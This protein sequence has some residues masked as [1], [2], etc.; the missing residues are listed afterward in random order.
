MALTRDELAARV[1]L[2][3]RDGEYVNLGIGLPTLVPNYLP[4]DVTVVLQSENGILGTGPYPTETAVD[5]DLINAGKET[6]TV[7]PGASFFDSATSF[8]M[9][10]GGHIDA[11]ILGAMQVSASGDI[12]NWMIPG[13][14]VKGMG[15]AMDLVHG[16]KRV[17]VMMEHVAK[18]GSHKI[19]EDCTLP[20]TGKGVVDRIIT[21]LAV[22]D[23]RPEGLV[24]V[25]TAPGVSQDDVFAATGAPLQLGVLDVV[26][27]EHRG[28]GGLAEVV[29]R[30]AVARELV[31]GVHRVVD[32]HPRPARL[33][34][35]DGREDA[36]ER[37]LLHPAAVGRTE[38]HDGR[39]GEVAVGALEDG[40]GVLG[41]RG[42]R[43]AR[44]AHDGGLRVVPEVHPRVDR[45]AVPADGDAGTVDVAEGLAVGRLDDLEDVDAVLLREA[46][47]LVGQPDVHVAVGRLGELGHLRGLAAAEVPDAVAA[48]QVGAVVE[49][50][51]GLVE[52]DPALAALGVDAADELGVA[53]QVGEDPAGV[54]ALGAEDQREV[55]AGAQARDLLDHRREAGARGAD[56]QRGL[57]GDEG[58]G[59]EAAGDLAGGGVHPAEVR[60][61]LDVDEERH[62]DDDG[63]ALGDGRGGVGGGPQ[64]ARRRDVG[65]QLGELRLARER[66]LAGVDEVDG[67]RVHVGA[68]DLVALG[69]E[70]HGQRE[71]D[72][73]Q[74]DDGDLHGD[75]PR[76]SETAEIPGYRAAAPLPD[77]RARLRGVRSGPPGPVPAVRGGRLHRA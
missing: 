13:K 2:E 12:A 27:L 21:D 48:R 62:D 25:E 28:V 77:H 8:G 54:D 72:L 30:E 46:G 26:G 47:E 32:Q 15:G 4:A 41:H 7:L 36:G 61:A 43:L 55:D 34:R 69:G 10:R 42:V 22:I 75:G 1:A 70:L 6:V 16:A 38:H 74:G 45:D 59:L 66:L 49:V 37:R 64:A 11:A 63:L 71:A 23:V 18:D 52:G 44:R 51:H 9:I 56:R 58:A 33:E 19:V 24:L 39:A 17:I 65:E 35:G 53:A 60:D 20:L 40:D 76:R 31:V 57:V 68:D 5:P 29:R 3:L 67:R 14:M 50:E 73:A